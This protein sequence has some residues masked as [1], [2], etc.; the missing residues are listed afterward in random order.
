MIAPF[1]PKSVVV[2]GGSNELTVSWQVPD[3]D[4]GSPITGYAVAVYNAAGQQVEVG[5]TYLLTQVL[6]GLR[7]GP[8]F[9]TVQAQNSQGYGLANAGSGT[10]TA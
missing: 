9:V 5:W 6:G 2:E 10:V 4:G 3:Y 7:P 1:Y 8:Y